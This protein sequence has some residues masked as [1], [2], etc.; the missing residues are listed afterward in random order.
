VDLLLPGYRIGSGLG[1]GITNFSERSS[2]L[3]YKSILPG[4]IVLGAKAWGHFFY[5]IGL[6][7]R[8]YISFAT[9]QQYMRC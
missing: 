1:A 8:L 2:P 9:T 6:T 4:I 7:D 3:S 5:V